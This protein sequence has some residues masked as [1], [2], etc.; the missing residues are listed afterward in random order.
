VIW[1]RDIGPL[2]RAIVDPPQADGH[3]GNG[4]FIFAA[5]HSMVSGRPGCR[6]RRF[7]GHIK[8]SAGNNRDPHDGV[9]QRR[10]PQENPSLTALRALFARHNHPIVSCAEHPTGPATTRKGPPS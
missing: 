2:T 10:P 3:C 4:Q 1:Y 7:G 5:R 9:C 8:T 6:P